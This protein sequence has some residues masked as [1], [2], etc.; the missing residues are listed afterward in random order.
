MKNI[1]GGLCGILSLCY[2]MLNAGGCITKIIDEEAAIRAEY[3]K[4][5]NNISNM[6][7]I[8]QEKKKL[9]KR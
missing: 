8:L 5:H 2:S 1:I 6:S 7:E 4:S 9:A 3:V